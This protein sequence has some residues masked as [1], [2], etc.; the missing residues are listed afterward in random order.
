[1]RLN[2]AYNEIEDVDAGFRF[3]GWCLLRSTR[4]RVIHGINSRQNLGNVIP[5]A[6]VL[7]EQLVDF[8]K[9]GL[10]LALT[11]CRVELCMELANAP[12]IIARFTT[13]AHISK[14]NGLRGDSVRHAYR[15][16]A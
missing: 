11:R 2:E 15:H 10:A 3:L 13:T 14:N 4:I 16:K 5:G 1:M 9:S 7:I 12:A 6:A 8:L